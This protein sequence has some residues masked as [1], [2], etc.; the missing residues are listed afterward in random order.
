MYYFEKNCD[1]CGNLM[2]EGE[3]I[4]VCPEC[5][6]PQHREC[7]LAENRCV[8]EHLHAEGFD[9]KKANE[10]AETPESEQAPAQTE[11]EIESDKEK[12][13]TDITGANSEPF[14]NIP[15]PT[16]QMDGMYVDGKMLDVNDVADGVSV[17]E[18]VN[19]TQ[20]NSK[21]YVKNFFRNKGKK[22]LLSWNWGAFFFTPAWFFYRKLYKLG[23]IFLALTV[24]ATLAVTPYMDTIMESYEVLTPM[25]EEL[26]EANTAYSEEQS[27]AN[28]Q[29]VEQIM[30]RIFAESKKIFPYILRVE[31]ITFIIPCVAA[32]LIANHFYR[33]KMQEDIYYAKQATQDTRVLNYSLLRRGGVSIMAGMFAML[34]ESYLPQ[35]IMSIIDSFIY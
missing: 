35:V 9:W 32:A 4:V 21:H 17:K 18:M 31:L 5:G 13:F 34:A 3:D 23:A 24:A 15:L 29:K 16:F 7:Y 2:H 6:T 28:A 1:G 8:N 12:S 26:R 14:P 33:K 11:P 20:I 25:M 27:D 22:V 10:T 19:Y 30:D